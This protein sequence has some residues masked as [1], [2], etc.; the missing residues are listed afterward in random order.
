MFERLDAVRVDAGEA[1]RAGRGEMGAGV[2]QIGLRVRQLLVA[3]RCGPARARG[4]DERIQLVDRAV[5]LD[6]RVV[7]R[8]ARAA[9]KRR[10]AAVAGSRVDLHAVAGYQF[11]VAW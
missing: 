4:A 2:E 6:A 9:E 5:S 1:A 10:L 11:P 7:F 8:Y 3:R